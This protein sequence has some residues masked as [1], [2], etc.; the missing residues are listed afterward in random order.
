MWRVTI[1]R[2]GGG[3]RNKLSQPK[4]A[5]TFTLIGIFINKEQMESFEEILEQMEYYIKTIAF[6]LVGDVTTP[7]FQDL[8]Q[9]GRIGLYKAYTRYDP[10]TGTPFKG[11]AFMYIKGHMMTYITNNG[12]TIRIAKNKVND[13]KWYE[14]F[15]ANYKPISL[16]VTVGVHHLIHVKLSDTIEDKTELIEDYSFVYE[17]LSLIKKDTTREMIKMYFGL[18]PYE[19]ALNFREIGIR[20]DYTMQHVQHLVSAELKKLKKNK[21]LKKLFKTANLTQ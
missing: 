9:E 13:K 1:N 6:R 3:F 18:A 5:Y 8:L 20:L 12:R 15:E 21:N 7:L 11:F 10:S 17:Y 14:E 2:Q 16:D 19:Q 4:I